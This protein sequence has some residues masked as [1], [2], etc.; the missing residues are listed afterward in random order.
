RNAACS[1]RFFSDDDS[2]GD[3]ALS[4]EY[5]DQRR[6][7]GRQSLSGSEPRVKTS[8]VLNHVPDFVT[9]QESVTYLW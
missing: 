5:Y 9:L 7:A 3:M 6:F 1:L 2:L 4:P 8:Q